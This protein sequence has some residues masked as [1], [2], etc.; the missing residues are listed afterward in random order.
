MKLDKLPKGKAR[1][2]SEAELPRLAGFVAKPQEKIAQA[3]QAATAE[4]RERTAGVSTAGAAILERYRLSAG[5]LVMNAMFHRT[6]RVTRTRPARR[7]HLPRAPGLPRARRRDPPGPVRHAPAAGHAPTRC[8]A[9]RSRCTTP[10]S[11]RGQADRRRR[12]LP[13]RRQDDRPAWR[14]SRPANRLRCGGRSGKPFLDVGSSGARHA[15]RRRHRPDAVP[16]LRP[17]TARHARL[18]RRCARASGR[19]RSRCTT[20]CAPRALAA[21]VDDFRAAGVEVHLASDDGSSAR[22]ASSRSCWHRTAR[23]ARSSA[24]ARSRCCTRWRRSA[25]TWE[26]PC[27]VSLE[28]PMACGVGIC[29][30]CVTKVQTPDG[31]DYKRVCVEGPVFDADRLV[32]E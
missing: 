4:A 30:S 26:V 2:V 21:G 14:K 15:G 6:A 32:W 22:R 5:Q 11:M 1:R 31:W 13:R 9:G 20:A 18:R 27:Q 8:W 17:R 25:R 23:P 10:S 16:G 7:A 3:A 29:F 12:R 24:A 19:R 28:T